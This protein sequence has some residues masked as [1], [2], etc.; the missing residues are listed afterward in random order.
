MRLLLITQYFPPEVGAPQSR[1]AALVEQLTQRGW[2]VTVLTAMPN[3][4][5]GKVDAAYRKSVFRIERN[6][7]IEIR[8]VW[9]YP[10]TGAGMKRLVSYI[11][12]AISS[13]MAQFGVGRPQYVFVESPPLILGVTGLLAGFWWRAP[14]ILN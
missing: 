1:L 6:G 12:F 7:S 2:T 11:S 3:Y 9:H 14:V 5:S 4:P 8:R 13:A 10:A